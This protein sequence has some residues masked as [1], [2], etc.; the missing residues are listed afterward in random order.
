MSAGSK[1]SRDRALLAAFYRA[2]LAGVDPVRAVRRAISDPEV[3]R[4]LWKARR[5]GIFAVGKA[6][7]GMFAG[8]AGDLLDFDR[9]LVIVPRGSAPVPE[10]RAEVLR[11]SHPEPDSSSVRAARRAVEFFSGFGREDLILC[12]ISGGTSSLLCMPKP[13]LTLS[14]KRRRIREIARAGASIGEVNRLRTSLSRVKGGGLARETAATLV[15]LVLS[16]VPGDRPALVGSGPTIRGRRRD[17]VRIVASNRTGIEA[18]R[19]FARSRGLAARIDRRRLSG[20]AAEEGAR[21]ARAVANLKR[22]TVLLA[23]GETTVRLNLRPGIG[24]RT[25]EL[26]L[27][28]ARS[29]DGLP[30]ALLAAGSDGRDGSSRA[31]GAFVD[32]T[33]LARARR[34]GLS[35][36]RALA[37]HDTEPFFEAL[38]DLFVTGPTGTNVCDWVFGIEAE[39]PV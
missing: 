15:T 6:A 25:L 7:A 36:E 17:L 13:G 5:T 2:A 18:A 12:L 26:A 38:G 19:A 9:A 32:G 10:R 30:V 29:I 4:R 20:E 31:A 24:G 39:S 35:V 22:R 27:G 37:R 28:A 33:T 34:R 11:S 23:G 8:V 14:Q 3:V 16:D 21:I 1:P